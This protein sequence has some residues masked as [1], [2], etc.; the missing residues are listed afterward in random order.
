MQTWTIKLP[1]SVYFWYVG[2][3][4]QVPGCG[5]FAARIH[6]TN[7]ANKTITI[8]AMLFSIVSPKL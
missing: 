7:V 6:K 3:R 8:V 2:S 4:D 1:A 5:W